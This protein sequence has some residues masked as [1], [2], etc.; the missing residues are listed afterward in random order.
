MSRVAVIM[1]FR[2]ASRWIEEAIRSAM[3]PEVGLLIA[4][5]DASTDDSAEIVRR[6]IAEFP[7]TL[8]MLGLEA[9]ENQY[10]A[11][12]LGVARALEGGL[13][14][15]AFLD[16]DD[17]AQPGRFLRQTNLLDEDPA[18]MV[19]GGPTLEIDAHGKEL[20]DGSLAL[21]LL[22]DPLPMMLRRFGI[23]LWT[24]TAMYRRAVFDALGGFISTPTM[25]DTDFAVRTAFWC[26]LNGYSMHNDPQPVN[27]RRIHRDQVQQTTGSSKAPYKVAVERFL[28]QKHAFFGVLYRQGILE[29]GHL[30]HP[31][32]W[33]HRTWPTTGTSKTLSPPGS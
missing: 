31:N 32:P 28:Q 21:E 8:T 13:D 16:A 23:G 9:H 1:P 12:N 24:C 30:H 4:V 10:V 17:V 18:R 14:Y 26:A 7:S 19:V 20:H 15:L 3:Q 33:V 6:L 27:L 11:M 29:S 22:E 2:N 25:G 5:D